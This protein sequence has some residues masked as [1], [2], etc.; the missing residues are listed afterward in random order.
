MSNIDPHTH[1]MLQGRLEDTTTKLSAKHFYKCT[2]LLTGVSCTTFLGHPGSGRPRFAAFSSFLSHLFLILPFVVAVSL[3]RK[4]TKGNSSTSSSACPELLLS[5]SKSLRMLST[6]PS[7]SPLIRNEVTETALPESMLHESGRQTSLAVLR[8]LLPQGAQTS[9]CLA[10]YASY[11]L[12]VHAWR[13]HAWLQ[14]AG[15]IARV[16]LTVTAYASKILTCSLART[17]ASNSPGFSGS[18]IE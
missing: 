18:A 12:P 14:R 10:Q 9:S 1:N 5:N 15:V 8:Y 17:A 7:P 3:N 6:K 4:Q 16:S 13:E 11:I 2:H